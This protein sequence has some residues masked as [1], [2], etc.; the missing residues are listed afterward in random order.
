MQAIN[1]GSKLGENLIINPSMDLWQRNTSFSSIANGAY[2]ADRW[3]Y[4]KSGAGVHECL[5]SADVPIESLSK[6]SM[7]LNVTTPDATMDVGDEYRIG[8]KIEGYNLTRIKGRNAFISFWVKASVAGTYCVAL[9]NE[10][11]DRSYVMEYSINQADTWEKKTLKFKH[12]TTGTWDYENGIGLSID[13]VLG[14]GSAVQTLTTN[15]WQSGNFVGTANQTNLLASNSNDFFLTQVQL[16]EG[17]G[18]IPFEKL[19]RDFGSEVELCQRYFE[20]S[21]D[22]DTAIGSA[23]AFSSLK[24]STALSGTD[25]YDMMNQDF[26]TEKRIIPTVSFY[27]PNTGANNTFY[28]VNT[29][30]SVGSAQ[31]TTPGLGKRRMSIQSPGGGLNGN[32]IHA[33]HWTADAEL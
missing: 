25:F 7:L 19:I 22:L 21:Y 2:L 27:N 17:I 32:Q 30:L 29:G 26:N 12:N 9:R 11:V 31:F 23:S 20:K 5:R 1:L 10:A 33:I 6:Y 3:N 24:Q 15:E 13:W 16:H 18:E 4:G 8:Q 14:C 28:N